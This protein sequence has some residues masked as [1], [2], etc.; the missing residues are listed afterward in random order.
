MPKATTNSS[1]ISS[2]IQLNHQRQLPSLLLSGGSDRN[3]NNLV[4][5]INRE[6]P[7]PY[8][9]R[10]VVNAPLEIRKNRRPAPIPPTRSQIRSRVEEYR[11][12]LSVSDESDSEQFQIRRRSRS[13]IHLRNVNLISGHGH[14]R[15]RT[16]EILLGK[17]FT[18][19]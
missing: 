18:K 10:A 9:K 19:Y 6:P 14:N 3:T 5:Y 1:Q 17:D 13:S 8:Q 11:N 12:R 16:N 7:P 2:S 4:N 15:R